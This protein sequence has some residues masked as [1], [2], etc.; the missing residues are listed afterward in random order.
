MAYCAKS[1][2]VER[3]GSPELAQLTDESAATSTD[4]GEIAK[5]CDE[6]TSLIDAYVAARYTTPLSPVPTVVR[7]WACDIAR[8]FLW[9]DRAGP[10]S[11]VTR[12]YEEAMA[13]MKDVAKGIAGLPDATGVAAVSSGAALTVIA[14]TRVFDASLLDSMPG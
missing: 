12:N 11:V 13:Q 5:A 6:A 8:K 2:L 10:D 1:D 3:F 14:P 4:D 7:K 9:K